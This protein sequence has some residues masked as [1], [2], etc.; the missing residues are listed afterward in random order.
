MGSDY[1]RT[2]LGFSTEQGRKV[3]KY[4]AIPSSEDVSTDFRSSA[5]LGTQT[6]V[7]HF[8]DPKRRTKGNS[9]V[10]A[11]GAVAILLLFSSAVA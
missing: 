5:D 11:M 6:S 1:L 2:T 3:V 7:K 10:F 4:E 8:Q 9:L